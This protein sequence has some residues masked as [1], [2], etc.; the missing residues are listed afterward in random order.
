VLPLPPYPDPVSESS[1]FLCT[2]LSAFDDIGL[3]RPWVF[4]VLAVV[5]GWI[6]VLTARNSVR[7]YAGLT[8]T[9]A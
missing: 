7:N 9:R 4:S 3:Q 5:S 1:S 8:L 2:C 6:T